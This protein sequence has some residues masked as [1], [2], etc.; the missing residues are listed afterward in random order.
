MTAVK[1]ERSDK[2]TYLLKRDGKI[3][4]YAIMMTSRAHGLFWAPFD[5]N[6]SRIGSDRFNHPRDVAKAMS[7]RMTASDG[8]AAEV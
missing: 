1:A 6:R 4:G 7:V 3:V 8:N 5:L 2:L